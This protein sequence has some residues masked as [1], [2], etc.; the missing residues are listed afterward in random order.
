MGGSRP[1]PSCNSTEGLLRGTGVC[2]VE[3]RKVGVP[4]RGHS[5]GTR[6]TEWCEDKR[7]FMKI[8][9]TLPGTKQ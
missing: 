6:H 2:Q 9:R 7:E 1:H 4:G 8:V 5:K 3:E